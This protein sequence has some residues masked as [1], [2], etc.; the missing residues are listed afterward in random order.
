MLKRDIADQLYSKA[1]KRFRLENPDITFAPEQLNLLWKNIYDI[2]Q[3]S[4]REAAEK[5]VD[6][7][8]FT[9]L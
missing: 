9:Y 5:Y 2:L 1:L 6:A 8:N 4:G 3:H 7:A